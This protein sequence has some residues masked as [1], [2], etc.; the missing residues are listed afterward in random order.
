MGSAERTVFKIWPALDRRH[1]PGA[2]PIRAVAVDG[3]A[4]K[5]YLGLEDGLLE[6]H[7]LVEAAGA[8]GCSLSAR[9]HVSKRASLPG[10]DYWCVVSATV[11]CS[12]LPAVLLQAL[13]Q[14]WRTAAGCALSSPPPTQALVAIAH[15]GTAGCLTVLTDDGSVH[16]LD[17]ESLKAQLL[18]LR[19]G[20]G[21][22]GGGQQAW[23]GSVLLASGVWGRVLTARR[24]D[25]RRR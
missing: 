12:G 2:S 20:R 15:L 17:C 6:E 24:Q 16:L 11:P 14:R 5:L 13:L 21:R 25:G 4:S 23:R 18:P 1:Q 19:W 8:V 7:T 22:E 9:K 3:S 10:V